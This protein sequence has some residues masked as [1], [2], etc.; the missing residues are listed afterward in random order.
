LNFADPKLRDRE[1]ASLWQPDWQLDAPD[2]EG[3]P[4][5]LVEYHGR[6]NVIVL[7]PKSRTEPC[8]ITRTL[9]LP[10]DKPTKISV[11]VASHD[12]GDWELRATCN[13]ERLA[14]SAK[15]NAKTP[16]QRWK[17]M[18]WDLTAYQGQKVTLRLENWASD[19]SNEFS[20]WSD[21]LIE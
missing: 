3:T 20:F 13:G 1:S 7:H 15:I 16:D 12:G 4:T 14:G 18:I 17:K 19:W 21:L 2:F 8:A 5:K 11:W 9:E 6:N 10:K